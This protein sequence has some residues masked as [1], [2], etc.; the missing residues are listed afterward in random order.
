MSDKGYL[1]HRSNNFGKVPYDLMI[2]TSITAGAVRLYAY[3]HWRYGSN[4]KNFE[5]RASMSDAIGVSTRTITKYAQELEQADWIT[6]IPRK[7]KQGSATNFYHV[8]ELQS[9]CVAWRSSTQRAKPLRIIEG[10]KGRAGIGG[11]PDHKTVN[12]SSPSKLASD[13]GNLSS[14]TPLNSSSHNPDSLE[15]EKEIAA[16]PPSPPAKQGGPVGESVSDHTPAQEAK[17]PSDFK[18]IQQMVVDHWFKGDW[19]NGGWAGDI[20]NL[21]LGKQEK[22][23]YKDFNFAPAFTPA[24]FQRFVSWLKTQGIEF[25][26]AAAKLRK[27]GNDFR[28]QAKTALPLAE[29]TQ[30]A[31]AETALYGDVA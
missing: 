26:T 3:M 4:C 8:F 25:P 7:N 23:Q 29:D 11:K 1:H 15:P 16:L 27:W 21:Y 19:V 9:D 30:S 10:R 28:L 5:G 24:E 12:S 18:L 2:D 13:D 14:P 17:A 20:A 6:I 22:Q 31:A